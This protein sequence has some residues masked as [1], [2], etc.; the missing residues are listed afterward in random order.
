MTS[1]QSY[2]VKVVEEMHHQWTSLID[3]KS[4]PGSIVRSELVCFIWDWH[5]INYLLCDLLCCVAKAPPSVTKLGS[6]HSQLLK[7]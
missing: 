4:K 5:L 2:A 6:S 3:G 7:K 1:F